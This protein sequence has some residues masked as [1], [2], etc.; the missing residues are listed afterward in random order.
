MSAI[1]GLISFDDHAP[2]EQHLRMMTA[3]M[4]Y[5]GPDG[6]NHWIKGNVALGHC[7]LQTT[8][9]SLEECQPL[10]DEDG[11]L[12]LVLDGR[13]DNRKSLRREL[14]AKGKLLRDASDAEL[15]LRAY[16]CWSSDCVTRLDGDFAFVIWDARQH[17]A[18]LAR[19]RM[20]KKPL[21]YW[22]AGNTLAFA[23]D[24]KALLSL[25]GS[26]RE[27]NEAMVA[28]HLA[29]DVRSLDETLI[30]GIMRL[31]P[32]CFQRVDRAG[33]KTSRYWDVDCAAE[34]RY[35]D[36]SEYAEHFLDLLR[37]TVR[38]QMR[39][40]SPV[41]IYLS[42]GV[43]SSTI[44]AIAADMAPGNQKP[45]AFSVV[46]PGEDYDEKPYIDSVLSMHKLRG[47]FVEPQAR[48]FSDFGKDIARHLDLTD[49]PNGADTRQLL[50]IAKARNIRVMLDGYGGDEWF[51]RGGH[52]YN[53]LMKKRD[54][55]RIYAH[56]K[57]Q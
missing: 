11:S 39:S 44:A 45:E 53:Y 12:T 6:I 18:F 31:P 2:P 27:V 16:E 19:D 34:I 7:L 25:P 49:G 10:G 3:A 36:E 26:P 32:A 41:G 24:F 43:D 33:H 9:E 8:P 14:I 30:R 15:V 40:V 37:N 51:G 29:V 47:H 17:Q 57:E 42:G 50:Q 22:R 1:A 21:Y 5:R 23:T 56:A 4:A 20:G 28:E 54:F 52:Y 13:I 38:S 35:K 48:P 46:Y 55:R